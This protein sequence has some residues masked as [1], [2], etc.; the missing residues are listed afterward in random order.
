MYMCWTDV[1]RYVISLPA[2][3][4]H[5][6]PH[7]SQIFD[8]RSTL[9]RLTNGSNQSLAHARML[10]V[11]LPCFYTCISCVFL[12]TVSAICYNLLTEGF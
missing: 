11:V 7:L 4:N 12:Q 9:T 3:R 10:Q 1:S 2:I 8:T 5:L 6:N